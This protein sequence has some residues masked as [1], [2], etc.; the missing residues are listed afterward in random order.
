MTPGP[1]LLP[2][3]P[4]LDVGNARGCLQQGTPPPL[5]HCHQ[6]LSVR[7][8]L[9]FS[10]S[11]GCGGVLYQG[12]IVLAV[13]VTSISDR[14]WRNPAGWLGGT[15]SNSSQPPSERASGDVLGLSP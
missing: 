6:L 9:P 7:L 1:G 3:A 8:L 11:L 4:K 14:H 12:Q 13:G 2:E 15:A 5:S 10:V